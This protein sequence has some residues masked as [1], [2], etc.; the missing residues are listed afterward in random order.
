M[1][2]NNYP[3]L[4]QNVSVNC[5]SFLKDQ[6]PCCLIY[7]LYIIML[8]KFVFFSILKHAYFHIG[9]ASTFLY[10]FQSRFVQETSLTNLSAPHQ[11]GGY[12]L[13]KIELQGTGSSGINK[14]LLH[15]LQAL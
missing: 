11:C 5:A 15:H 14:T 6:L 9:N 3:S 8:K 2:P 12:T 13:Q 7:F 4:Q 10:V 1:F